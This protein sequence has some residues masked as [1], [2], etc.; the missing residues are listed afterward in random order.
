MPLKYPLVPMRV[1]RSRAYNG[2]VT[3]ALVGSM[4]YYSMTVLWPS[5]VSNLYTTDI[6]YAGWLSVTVGAGTLLGQVVGGALC[7]PLGKQKWQMVINAVGMT[8]FV[9]GL[10][11]S[12][13]N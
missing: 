1:F 3:T 7:E 9:G 11:A 2:I 6:M 12:N 4:I 5:Q 10:A 8:A 13:Q